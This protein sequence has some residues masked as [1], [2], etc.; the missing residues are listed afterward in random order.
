MKRKS[1]NKYWLF[2]EAAVG[3]YEDRGIEE[4][5]FLIQDG[6]LSDQEYDIFLWTA[7]SGP[8]EL[9]EAYHGWSGYTELPEDDYKRI[10][11]LRD[12]I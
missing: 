10:F 1:A 7:E 2:G 12:E 9:L 11:K 8:D 4:F 3:E 5:L 6:N